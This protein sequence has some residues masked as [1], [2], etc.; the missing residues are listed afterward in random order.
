[1]VVQEVKNQIKSV[2]VLKI[3]IEQ[4]KSRGVGILDLVRRIPHGH[5]LALAKPPLRQCAYLHEI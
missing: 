5:H 1:M 3:R 2:G 4:I